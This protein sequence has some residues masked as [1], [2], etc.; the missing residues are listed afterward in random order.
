VFL[1]DTDFDTVF[2]DRNIRTPVA[3]VTLHTPS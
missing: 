1:A 2:L 3:V